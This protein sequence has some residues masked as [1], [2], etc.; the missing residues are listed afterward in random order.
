M[1]QTTLKRAIIP[2]N[3]GVQVGLT[4]LKPSTKAVSF[5]A[6]IRHVQSPRSPGNPKS[7]EWFALIRGSESLKNPKP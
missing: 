7:E 2:H 3:F 1:A 4:R 5:W 6:H